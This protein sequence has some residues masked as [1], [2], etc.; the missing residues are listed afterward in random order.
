MVTL[1][2]LVLIVATCPFG[3]M[4]QPPTECERGRRPASVPL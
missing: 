4:L 2:P 1:K 3:Q